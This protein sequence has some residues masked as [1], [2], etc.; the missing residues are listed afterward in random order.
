MS[1][2]KFIPYIY[3]SSNYIYAILYDNYTTCHKNSFIFGE[4]K[5]LEL[6]VDEKLDSLE[7]I[8]FSSLQNLKSSLFRMKSLRN[9]I[10]STNES[11]TKLSIENMTHNEIDNKIIIKAIYQNCPNLIYLKLML[12]NE[13]ILELEQLLINCQYLIG[14]YFINKNIFGWDKL[15]E[16]LNLPSPIKEYKSEGIIKKFDYLYSEFKRF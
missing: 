10:I 3:A 16:I 11:L 2:E 9:L 13:N 8:S 1:V 12:I 6:I 5:K 7:N 4:F 14:F 15:F